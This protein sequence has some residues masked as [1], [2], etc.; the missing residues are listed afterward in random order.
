M[1]HYLVPVSLAALLTIAFIINACQKSEE[2]TIADFHYARSEQVIDFTNPDGP[3]YKGYLSNATD[4]SNVGI[5][6][7][8]ESE[9]SIAE[10]YYQERDYT[11]LRLN[12]KAPV[13]SNTIQTAIRYLREGLSQ[14][15]IFLEKIFIHNMTDGK[16]LGTISSLQEQVTGIITNSH[17]I[18]KFQDHL[19][20]IA[21]RDLSLFNSSWLIITGEQEEDL[22]FRRIV[23]LEQQYYQCE[24]CRPGSQFIFHPGQH[25]EWNRQVIWESVFDF[26]EGNEITGIN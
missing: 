1:N 10:N 18:G 9:G 22:L 6:I 26:I 21:Q 3:S 12:H 14:K 19:Q 13:T 17:A 8:N 25:T 11:V 23:V 7:L 15:N 24:V 2:S 5:I 16:N 4:Q 20:N